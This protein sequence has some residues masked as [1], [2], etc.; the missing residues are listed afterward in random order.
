MKNY[1]MYISCPACK[2]DRFWIASIT[3]LSKCSKDLDFINKI[4]YI[5]DGTCEQCNH[6]VADINELEALL[7]GSEG[8]GNDRKD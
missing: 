4:A 5:V 3:D 7:I 2:G 6:L 8:T 1:G